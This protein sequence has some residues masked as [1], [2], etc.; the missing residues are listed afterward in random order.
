MTQKND[1][2]Y[3]TAEEIRD[4]DDED[5]LLDWHDDLMDLNDSLLAALEIRASLAI[6]DRVWTIR[7]SDKAV[8][9]QTNLRRVE[10]QLVNCGFELP[11]VS[12]QARAQRPAEKEEVR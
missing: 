9:V 2:G 12:L 7:T 1:L 11:A 5:Q 3:L 6:T 4:C 8:A 10:R